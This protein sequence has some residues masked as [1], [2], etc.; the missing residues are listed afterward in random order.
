MPD[1]FPDTRFSTFWPPQMGS[2]NYGRMSEAMIV[3]CDVSAVLLQVDVA[4][5]AAAAMYMNGWKE[6]SST[7]QTE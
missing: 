7:G 3:V 6:G 4:S 2:G 5:F 1:A